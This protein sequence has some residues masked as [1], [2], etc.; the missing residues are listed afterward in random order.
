MN[1]GKGMILEQFEDAVTREMALLLE[2]NLKLKR[3]NL[4][5]LL[6]LQRAREA[7]HGLAEKA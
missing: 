7:R 3:R 4:E 6:E 2:E 5:L 1:T